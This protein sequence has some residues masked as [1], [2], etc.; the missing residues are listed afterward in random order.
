MRAGVI[1]AVVGAAMHNA[2][3]SDLQAFANLL[4]L[5]ALLGLG[6]AFAVDGVYALP[7]RAIERRGTALTITLVVLTVLAGLGL[8]EWYANQ[9]K[10]EMLVSHVPQAAEYYSAARRFDPPPTPTT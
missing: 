1:A 2:V 7:V 4:T 9:G 10:Y 5:C 3:D 6:L 8:G